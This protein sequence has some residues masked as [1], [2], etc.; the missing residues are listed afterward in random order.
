MSS[1]KPHTGGTVP[2]GATSNGSN[3]AC[4]GTPTHIQNAIEM[5]RDDNFSLKVPTNRRKSQV[6]SRYVDSSDNEES[7]GSRY[8]IA[9]E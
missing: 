8:Q 6:K 4:K 5:F 1:K 9:G 7:E 2:G 3:S